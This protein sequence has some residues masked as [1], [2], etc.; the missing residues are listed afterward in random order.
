MRHSI[1][2]FIILFSGFSFA[3]NTG[4]IQGIVLDEEAFNEPLMYANISIEGT[5]LESFSDEYG[6]FHFE[7]L[8][9]GNYT[10][11]FSF[12]GYET[13][14]LTVQVAS[15]KQTNISASLMA[16]TIILSDLA[17]LNKVEGQ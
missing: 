5:A 16:R 14:V 12:N 15:N 9:D 17:S 4:S 6:I 11:V 13:K 3:Q 1:F 2:L 8:A 7:N 10:L